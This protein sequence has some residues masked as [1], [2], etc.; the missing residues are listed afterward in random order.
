M[1]VKNE[2]HV[3]RD[4]LDCLKSIISYWVICD[5][6]STDGTQDIICAYFREAGIP[7]ELK[8]HT[9]KDFGTNRSLALHESW[10]LREKHKCD[11]VFMF[12][13]DDVIVGNI[14]F[15]PILDADAYYLK[16]GSAFTYSRMCLFRC[17]SDLRWIYKG[18]LH[19]FPT[20][21]NN[22]ETSSGMLEG[23]YFIDSRR[24]GARN[25]DNSKY[26]SDAHVLEGALLNE[27]D[28]EMRVRYTFYAAQSYYDAGLYDHALMM[29]QKRVTMTGWVQEV[30]YSALRVAMIMESKPTMYSE[31]QI[32]TA[33]CDAF[34]EDPERAEP[35][36]FLSKYFRM[37]SKFK[38]GYAFG[39][40][41]NGICC[42]LT[43]K[44]FL[45]KDVYDFKIKDEL[46]VC[47]YWTDRKSECEILC[48]EILKRHDLSDIDRER[49]LKNLSLCS[50]I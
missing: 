32:L 10:I 41:A 19:E 20:C 13:A 28:E 34:K 7:G 30:F 17:S 40:L 33:Y 15:P 27:K 21:F 42:P 50:N 18:V 12:D 49:V 22:K 35:F 6:A 25:K 9:W 36:Y 37:K 14:E 38:E 8:Q 44:L 39:K 46:A 5:T 47:A 43:T 24:L 31:Q 48:K 29:Y 2:A 3:V 45:F 4:A 23:A 16:F 26:L 11:Y 1:I